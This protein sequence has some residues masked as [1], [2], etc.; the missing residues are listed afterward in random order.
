MIKTKTLIC[1][2][3]FLLLIASACQRKAILVSDPT[4]WKVVSRKIEYRY[5]DG[6]IR[7]YYVDEHRWELVS[8]SSEQIRILRQTR[9]TYTVQVTWIDSQG[10]RRVDPEI[11]IWHP[12]SPQQFLNRQKE[13]FIGEEITS[14]P[15]EDF[16]K[17]RAQR[18]QTSHRAN[19]RG[20]S[21]ILIDYGNSKQYYDATT[22]VLLAEYRMNRQ[23]LSLHK[24][25]LELRKGNQR[26]V[27]EIVFTE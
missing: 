23:I 16:I 8:E 4:G 9:D 25:H 24:G 27:Y 19:Y 7:T 12:N 3:V 21:A 17:S 26:G 15:I 14:S 18:A 13:A 6:R 1:I 11:N 2:I 20:R 22:G 10:S 5:T